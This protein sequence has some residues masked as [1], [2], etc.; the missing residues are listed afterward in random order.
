[1]PS[2]KIITNPFLLQWLKLKA[3]FSRK[4]KNLNHFGGTYVKDAGQH[5]LHLSR[6]D[7][8]RMGTLAFGDRATPPLS[9]MERMR[10]KLYRFSLRVTEKLRPKTVDESTTRTYESGNLG[11]D[12]FIANRSRP[13]PPKKASTKKGTKKTLSKVE[14]SS[15]PIEETASILSEIGNLFKPKPTVR[16]P[17]KIIED[18]RKGSLAKKVDRFDKEKSMTNLH[19]AVDI[20]KTSGPKIDTNPSNFDPIPEELLDHWPKTATERPEELKTH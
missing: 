12:F 14:F 11:Q 7:K 2:L 5:Y 10:E 19:D 20:M 4:S 8:A 3:S 13:A 16:D 17:K 1:M 18:I 6:E 15:V 9:F